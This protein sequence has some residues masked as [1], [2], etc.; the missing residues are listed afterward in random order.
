VSVNPIGR[1]GGQIE[2]EWSPP[3]KRQKKTCTPISR[4]GFYLHDSVK[5]YSHGCIEVESRL[6]THLREHQKLSKAQTLILQV[7]YVVGRKINGGT[8]I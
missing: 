1:I 6:F 8:K 5:G 4:G 3:T 7:K 2:R